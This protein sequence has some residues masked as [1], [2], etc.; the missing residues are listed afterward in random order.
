[1]KRLLHPTK[2]GV[3]KKKKKKNKHIKLKIYFKIKN[4]KHSSIS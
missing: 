1:M 2:R 3:T 4:P